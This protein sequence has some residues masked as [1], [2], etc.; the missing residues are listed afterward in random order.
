MK[1]AEGKKTDSTGEKDACVPFNKE[2]PNT[3]KSKFV[4]QA[5]VASKGNV[6]AEIFLKKGPGNLQSVFG[7]D[8][9]YWDDDSEKSVRFGR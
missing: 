7:S 2:F 5:E 9:K 1:S 4:S 6:S 8:R 3:D